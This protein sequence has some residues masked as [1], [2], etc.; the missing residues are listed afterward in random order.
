MITLRIDE[1][2]ILLFDIMM[3]GAKPDKIQIRFRIDI[4]TMEIG[5]PGFIVDDKIK[6]VIPPLN[7]ILKKEVIGKYRGKLRIVYDNKLYMKPWED[8][9]ELKIEPRVD[10]QL[11]KTIEK[12][13]KEDD[14]KLKA[15]LLSNES[16]VVVES[17]EEKPKPTI[18]KTV[19]K[20]PVK[21][22]HL[23]NKLSVGG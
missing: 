11:N 7:D 14:I 18:T 12:E 8:D 1:E 16:D 4:E 10:A 17:V 19:K 13:V 23:R 22:M 9:V 5:F 21:N 3:E 15:Y 6:V 20:E 2:K